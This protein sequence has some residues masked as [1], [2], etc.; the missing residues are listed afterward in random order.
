MKANYEMLFAELGY[1]ED[2]QQFLF[3]RL[4]LLGN[5]EED[6]KNYEE[7]SVNDLINHMLDL[8]DVL[9]YEIEKLEQH[10][11]QTKGEQR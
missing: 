4:G 9:E 2:Y 3:D 8:I 1:S 10:Q 5:M 6:F 11:K 7:L